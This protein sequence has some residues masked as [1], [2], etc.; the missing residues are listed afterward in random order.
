ME[1]V[2]VVYLVR[3]DGLTPCPTPPAPLPHVTGAPA[4]PASRQQASQVGLEASHLRSPA[5]I[6]WRIA[7]RTYARSASQARSL[8]SERFAPGSWRPDR[9]AGWGVSSWPR[10]LLSHDATVWDTRSW[11]RQD[12][13]SR[14]PGSRWRGFQVSGSEPERVKHCALHCEAAA[15][16]G[17]RDARRSQLQY[18]SEMYTAMG[19]GAASCEALNREALTRCG[20]ASAGGGDRLAMP[21][22]ECLG[23]KGVSL[24]SM[25]HFCREPIHRE[26]ERHP[27]SCGAPWTQR[28]INDAPGLRA[29]G[30]RSPG[31]R[32]RVDRECRPR[33]R[34]QAR[35]G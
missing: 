19:R 17:C 18:E 27:S 28:P 16:L 12:E 22:F 33:R 20:L 31:A 30:C 7:P 8:D 15:S 13:A 25:R 14:A 11:T 24:H 23:T 4:R 1:L 10:Q 35:G 21:H 3:M 2:S 32:G 9:R 6:A 5:P 26:R 34:G 29:L